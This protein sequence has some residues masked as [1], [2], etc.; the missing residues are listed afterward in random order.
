MKNNDSDFAV[1]AEQ[2]FFK[3]I[4][5]DITFH[6]EGD[7]KLLNNILWEMDHILFDVPS[8]DYVAKNGFDKFWIYTYH[9]DN[10][11]NRCKF[12]N[13]AITILVRD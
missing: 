4:P 10:W 5:I 3:E 9:Y 7:N 13:R 1:W 12:S 2:N 6:D 8:E 11:K